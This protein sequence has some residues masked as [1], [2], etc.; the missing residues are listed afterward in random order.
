MLIVILSRSYCTHMY[1]VHDGGE[2]GVLLVGAV[3]EVDGA[4][5]VLDIPKLRY[6]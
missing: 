2:L 6:R 4:V 3:D 5:K 1:L